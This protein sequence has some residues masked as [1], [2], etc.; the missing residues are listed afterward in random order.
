MQLYSLSAD[1]SRCGISV[2]VLTTFG[3]CKS[4]EMHV[5]QSLKYRGQKVI[6]FVLFLSVLGPDTSLGILSPTLSVDFS[7][8]DGKPSFTP[9]VGI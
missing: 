6:E 8:Y 4:A 9:T 5:L 3:M 2:T 7:S 1:V